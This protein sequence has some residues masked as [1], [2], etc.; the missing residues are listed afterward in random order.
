MPENGVPVVIY[1]IVSF[2]LWMIQ[3]VYGNPRAL[4]PPGFQANAAAAGHA[5]IL[6]QQ[7]G[8]LAALQ[9]H[10]QQQQQLQQQA[11]QVAL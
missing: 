6:Q 2:L 3:G 9:Q 11:K 7:A 5:Q 10:Q 4:G 8:A 1:V